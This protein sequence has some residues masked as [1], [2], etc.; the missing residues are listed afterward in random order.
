MY[1]RMAGEL[2]SDSI[3]LERVREYEELPQENNWET[4]GGLDNVRKNILSN[5]LKILSIFISVNHLLKLNVFTKSQKN[6]KSR[7]FE[8]ENNLMCF[9]R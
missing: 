2:E 6:S 5:F 1:S 3:A 9:Q 7:T 8:Q 4:E